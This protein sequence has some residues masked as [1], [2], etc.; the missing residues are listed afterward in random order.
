MSHKTNEQPNITELGNLLLKIQM[1]KPIMTFKKMFKDQQA[2][3]G[4]TKV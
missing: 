1:I 3:N 4:N 2:L